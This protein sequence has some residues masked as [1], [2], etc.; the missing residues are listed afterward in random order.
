MKG[1]WDGHW[2]G[3]IILLTCLFLENKQ[4]GAIVGKLMGEITGDIII[5]GTKWCIRILAILALLRYL[6][7]F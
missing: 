2:D 4:K 3:V 5:L 7:W 1:K 6:G